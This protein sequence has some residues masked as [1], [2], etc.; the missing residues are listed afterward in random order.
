[1]SGTRQYC[2]VQRWWRWYAH[3]CVL[4]S[5]NTARR[6][7][8]TSIIVAALGTPRWRTVSIS[9][10]GFSVAVGLKSE[11]G[12]YIVGRCRTCYLYSIVVNGVYYLS[13]VWSTNL[14]MRMMMEQPEQSFAYAFETLTIFVR[15]SITTKTRFGD[16]SVQVRQQSLDQPG[17][18]GLCCTWAYYL[19]LEDATSLGH[20]Y[21]RWYRITYSMVGDVVV[22]IVF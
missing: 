10:D 18:C 11:Y 12:L 7:R 21:V 6:S 19:C 3:T 13:V 14:M 16:S 20:W 1:M 15:M 4:Y 9:C 2:Q 17:T 8:V 5:G 22:R